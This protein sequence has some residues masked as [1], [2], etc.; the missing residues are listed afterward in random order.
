MHPYSPTRLLWDTSAMVFLLYNA[1]IIPFRLCFN[2]TDYCPSP[3]WFFESFVD[4][5]F[6]LD[7]GINFLTA[8]VHDEGP[9]VPGGADGRLGVIASTYARGWLTTDCVS[10]LPL[11]FFFSLSANQC[12]PGTVSDE[13]AAGGVEILKLARIIR[14]TKLVK[15]LRLIKLSDT[16]TAISDHMPI[17]PE[18]TFNV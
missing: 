14:L 6:V 13:N 7:I 1:A 3:I 5:F 9:E 11:D 12:Q 2:V 16:L 4:W 17:P 10:S 15:L 8:V 18:V